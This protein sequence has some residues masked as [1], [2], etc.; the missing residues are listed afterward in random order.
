MGARAGGA[1][2]VGRALGSLT[3]LARPWGSLLG[4]MP[5]TPWACRG[6]RKGGPRPKDRGS[7]METSFSSESL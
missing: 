3:L 1:G 4:L 7:V 2:T 6:E 5:C